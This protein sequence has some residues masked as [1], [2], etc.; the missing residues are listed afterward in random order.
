MTNPNHLKPLQDP[1]PAF[2]MW[3]QAGV[4][5]EFWQAKKN[6]YPIGRNRLRV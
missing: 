6:A 1:A 2:V 3:D 5:A 4:W